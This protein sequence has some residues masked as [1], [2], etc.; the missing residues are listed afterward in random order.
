MLIDRIIGAFTFRR[1]VYAEVEE[2]TSFTTTA[3]LLVLL[4]GF[5][6]QLGSQASTDLLDWLRAVV[7]GTI[8]SVVAFAVAAWVMNW[9]GRQLYNADVTF[10]EMV[11]TL[12]LAYVWNVVGVVGA[13]SAVS[14]FL[15][16]PILTCPS[17]LFCS[18]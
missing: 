17:V 15:S 13:L 2:D 6:N 12:G 9:V 4:I 16:C 18:S 10:D 14:S 7:V 1:A 3:W 11:R 5:L 8:W